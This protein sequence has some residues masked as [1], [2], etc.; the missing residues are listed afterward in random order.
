MNGYF[1][2]LFSL[3]IFYFASSTY[4]FELY[5]EP[6]VVEAVCNVLDTVVSRTER[7]EVKYIVTIYIK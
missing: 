7:S 1:E 4:R 5:K 6:I 2:G 3:T